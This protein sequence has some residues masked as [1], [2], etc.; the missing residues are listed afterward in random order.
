MGLLALRVMEQGTPLWLTVSNG[1]PPIET[2]PWR[3]CGLEL[4][5]MARGKD[6]LPV[7]GFGSVIQDSAVAAPQLQLGPV[8]NW[9]LSGPPFEEMVA[10]ACESEKVQP[11]PS[12]VIEIGCWPT[13]TMACLLSAAVLFAT[14]SWIVEWPLLPEVV[15]NE[16][17]GTGLVAVQEQDG[18]GWLSAIAR[19][20]ALAEAETTNGPAGETAKPQ[21]EPSCPNV[22]FLP[23]MTK[24]VDRLFVSL[25]PTAGKF[26]ATLKV[27]DP[28]PVAEVDPGVIHGTDSPVT[29]HEQLLPATTLMLPEPPSEATLTFNG[30]TV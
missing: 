15:E 5:A 25:S 7:P 17:Q 12:W 30:R 3:P 11:A 27:N 10:L 8:V 14:I 16:I 22:T 4:G 23:A 28:I 29:F 20:A 18:P 1:C 13:V 2:A 9:R 19:F 21:D 26:E 6:P 24:V